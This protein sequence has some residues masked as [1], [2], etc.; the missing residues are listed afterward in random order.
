MLDVFVASVLKTVR[1]C[2]FFFF[3]GR[4]DDFVKSQHGYCL[5]LKYPSLLAHMLGLVSSL[6]SHVLVSM[7]YISS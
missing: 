3:W 6:V 2:E 1:D 4:F 7:I 5:K